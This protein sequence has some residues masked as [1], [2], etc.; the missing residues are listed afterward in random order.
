M[1]LTDVGSDVVCVYFSKTVDHM[2]NY[3]LF[4]KL[5]IFNFSAGINQWTTSYLSN[6]DMFARFHQTLSIL[7]PVMYGVPQGSILNQLLF[8]FSMNDVPSFSTFSC[9]I[10]VDNVKSWS[11]A[12]RDDTEN[13]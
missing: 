7:K 10:Y 5:S 3:N 1:Q 2:S 9:L 6:S 12:S 8:L 13:T 11:K 4:S